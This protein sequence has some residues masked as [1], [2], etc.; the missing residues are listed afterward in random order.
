MR[1]RECSFHSRKRRRPKATVHVRQRRVPGTAKG[2]VYGPVATRAYPTACRDA[3]AE[4]TTL[5]NART[6]RARFNRRSE[7]VTTPTT[8][9]WAP[10]RDAIPELGYTARRI[11]DLKSPGCRGSS[12]GCREECRPEP[13]R[14]ATMKFLS[15]DIEISNVFDLRPGEDI[16]KYAPFDVA[17]AATQIAGGEHRLWFSPGPD[18]KPLVNLQQKDAKELLDY[19]ERMQREGYAVCAWN[20]L[21][22][23]LQWIARAAGDVP[24][25][26]R[27]ARALF[28]PMFQFF[29]LK[30]FP[31]ALSAVA[32][33]LGIGLTKSMDAA[34][35]PREWRAG[36]FQAVCD[37]V[38]GD[39]RMTNEI[40]TGIE[41]RREIAWTTQRGKRSTVPLPRLRTVEDCLRDPMPDQSWMDRPMPQEKFT[42][43]LIP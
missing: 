27:I 26:S 20:G 9:P 32:D 34:A 3:V 15:F 21:S 6:D 8:H 25:A 4:P 42:H 24:A 29:K 1:D 2:D 12:R 41:R 35:A 23:D 36:R 14:E 38:L 28:D 13:V 43:W 19:L 33:G 11:S 18:E 40:V 30:G 16:N 5:L 37:Y 31:V 10:V 17:V 22:F 39:A 7:R